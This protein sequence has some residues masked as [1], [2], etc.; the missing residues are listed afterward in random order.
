MKVPGHSR[1][2]FLGAKIMYLANISTE[3]AALK[4]ANRQSLVMVQ[5]D[6]L[7]NDNL[8]KLTRDTQQLSQRGKNLIENLITFGSIKENSGLD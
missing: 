7:S 6:V 2:N 3:N 4:E 1:Y 8:E 5:R